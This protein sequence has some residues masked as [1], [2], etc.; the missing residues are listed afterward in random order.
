[1]DAPVKTGF[2]YPALDGLRGIAVLCVVMT[3]IGFQ[4]GQ[5]FKGELGALLSRLDYG[6]TIFFLLS[7]FLLYSPFARAEMTGRP[8]PPVRTYLRNRALRI[9]PA[10]WLSVIVVMRW[11]EAGSWNPVDVLRQLLL[12]QVY[13]VGH[14]L[15]H[16]DQTWSLCVEVAFYLLLPLLALAVRGRGLRGQAVMLGAMVVTAIAWPVVTRAIGWPDVRIA[17]IWLPQFLD[18][19]ALG[20][21]L[22]VLRAWHDVGGGARLLDQIGDAAWTCWGMAALLLWLAATPLG[23]SRGLELLTTGQLLTKHLLYA[24]SATFL[25]LPAVFGAQSRTPVRAFLES[26]PMRWLGE[27]SYGVFLWHLLVMR[28][29]YEVTGHV[30]FDGHALEATAVIIPVSLFIAWLSFRL[31]E[32][33]ALSLKR[34]WETVGR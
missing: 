29:Y 31:V 23:G 25:L 13:S 28:E 11:T 21:G 3:H 4:T 6:V 22:A 18:W 1:M 30:T 10:Y 16:L 7:G 27:V 19:F 32:R 33:P 14:L 34:R 17:T 8:M 24:A 9:L 20:M 2:T 5:T 15:R 12:V 26:R